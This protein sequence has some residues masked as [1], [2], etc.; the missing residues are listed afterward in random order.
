[1]ETMSNKA[2]RAWLA[3]LIVD[4][5]EQI[6][7]LQNSLD[8]FGKSNVA[9]PAIQDISKSESDGKEIVSTTYADPE[10]RWADTR[11]PHHFDLPEDC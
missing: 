5:K 4:T 2:K 1:M 8:A 7:A 10:E 9:V 3:N 6:T 11:E